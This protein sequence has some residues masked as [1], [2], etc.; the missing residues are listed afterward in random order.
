MPWQLQ[1]NFKLLLIWDWD[2]D[3][4]GTSCKVYGKLALVIGGI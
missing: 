1:N 2:G 3:Q 4:G